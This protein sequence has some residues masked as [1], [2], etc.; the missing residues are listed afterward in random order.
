VHDLLREAKIPVS[1][2]QNQLVVEAEGE[3]LWVVG[4]AQAE[5][6]R[7]PV[8]AERVLILNVSA[9]HDEASICNLD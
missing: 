1:V 9:S 2:R 8:G 6:T 5:S 7:V 3:I 4:V